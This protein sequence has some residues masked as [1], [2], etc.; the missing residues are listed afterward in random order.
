MV[1]HNIFLWRNK[2]NIRFF[3]FSVEKIVLQ[4]RR[5]ILKIFFFSMKKYSMGT[6]EKHL[7]EVLLMSTLNIKLCFHGEI[8]KIS[9]LFS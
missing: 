5:D 3:F 4:I 1:T 9:L 7:A 6:H 8:R 2:K